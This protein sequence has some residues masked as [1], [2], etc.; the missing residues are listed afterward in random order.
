MNWWEVLISHWG[1][2]QLYLTE[3]NKLSGGT[4]PG[5]SDIFAKNST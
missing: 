4:K 3:G 5:F 1:K 2:Q